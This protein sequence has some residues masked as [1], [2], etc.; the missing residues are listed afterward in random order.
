MKQADLRRLSRSMT[1]LST[2]GVANARRYGD[3][4]AKLPDISS[5]D[6]KALAGSLPDIAALG[7]DKIEMMKPL[8]EA[9]AQMDRDRSDRSG[10]TACPADGHPC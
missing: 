2:V 3:L 1:D 8:V 6:L 7:V 9:L 10:G 5:D 4:L